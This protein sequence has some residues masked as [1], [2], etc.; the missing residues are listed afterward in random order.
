MAFNITNFLS[1]VNKFGIAKTNM[2]EVF[3]GPATM[4]NIGPLNQMAEASGGTYP[5]SD[6]F[7]NFRCESVEFPG[8]GASVITH[9]VYGPLHQ[10]PYNIT[11]SPI[12]MT[13]LLS[14]ALREKVFFESWMEYI[15]GLDNVGQG[16]APKYNARYYDDY[17]AD[18]IISQYEPANQTKVYS[19]KLCE[20]F[21][22]NVNPL[23]A[24][25]T[26]TNTA[27]KLTVQFAY[28]RWERDQSWQNLSFESRP[29]QTLP[30][31]A[32]AGSAIAGAFASKMS[33]GVA[34]AL[35]AATGVPAAAHNISNFLNAQ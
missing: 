3:I 7:L 31:L 17:K 15:C 8:R 25:R 2:F 19:A 22:L 13:F 28:K 34:Q 27:M 10:V 23:S 20:A 9:R 6:D 35:G 11:V 33:P 1:N 30:A 18:I 14:T 32:S 29:M 24:N 21:P 12:V 4:P 26:D 16:P 5:S